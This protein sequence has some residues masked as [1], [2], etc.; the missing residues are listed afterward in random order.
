MYFNIFKRM[1]KNGGF[2]L[3]EIIVT[4]VLSA[5]LGTMLIT[6]MG[7]T[8]TG[9]VQ[10]VLRVQQAN[11]AIGAMEKITTDYNKLNFD[12]IGNNTI[13][14]LGTL[15][16]YVQNGNVSTNTPYYGAYTIV[17]GAPGGNDYVILNSDGTTA[18]IAD[19]TGNN[20]TLRV[21]IT[22]GGQTLT[23][24]FTK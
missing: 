7:T 9:S 14:V 22:Q 15:K 8:L 23:T 17:S 16:G 10:P 21:S 3:I 1:K 4:L 2:T 5:I 20:R 13:D 12:Y 24:L 11:Y 18:P 19:G 6:F